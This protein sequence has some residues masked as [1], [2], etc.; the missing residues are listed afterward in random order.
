MLS[1][2]LLLKL[3]ECVGTQRETII[4]SKLAKTGVTVP[5]NIGCDISFKQ[6]KDSNLALRSDMN[7]FAAI[8]H[9]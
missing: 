9:L 4:F 5:N 1:V 8:A 7:I 3:P 2:D 6:S